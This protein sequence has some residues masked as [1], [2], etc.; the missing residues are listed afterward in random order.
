MSIV[1]PQCN[2]PI[3][4][5]TIEQD[6]A[7]CPNCDYEFSVARLLQNDEDR[8]KMEMVHDIPMPPRI[9]QVVDGDRL[10]ITRTWQRWNG[11]FLVIFLTPFVLSIWLMFVA[12][13]TGKLAAVVT[14]TIFAIPV[15]IVAREALQK[16]LNKTIIQLDPVEITVQDV[17]ITAYSSV[18]ATQTI[19]QAYVRRIYREKQTQ[20]DVILILDT[21]EHGMLVK[22]LPN[23]VQA[24]YI[25]QEIEKFLGIAHAPVRGEYGS[26]VGLLS[27]LASLFMPKPHTKYKF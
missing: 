19:I 4:V 21:G 25:E 13:F 7:T 8:K 5:T 1:C 14:I 15:A 11:V 23:A 6:K 17:P 9:H 16:L 10:V 18:F 3:P 22:N 26:N 12:L 27:C 24:Q 20:F 2:T